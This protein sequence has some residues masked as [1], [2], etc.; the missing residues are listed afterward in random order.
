[1]TE[2]PTIESEQVEVSAN[3]LQLLITNQQEAKERHYKEIAQL[4][5]TIKARDLEVQMYED[6]IKKLQLNKQS[7]SSKQNASSRR[8]MEDISKG[9]LL[10]EWYEKNKEKLIEEEYNKN[11]KNDVESLRAKLGKIIGS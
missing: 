11:H 10:D 4:K 7:H 1:M 2:T 3:K 6:A 5:A 9:K 8:I